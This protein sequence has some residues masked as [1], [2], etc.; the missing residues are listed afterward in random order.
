MKDVKTFPRGGVHLHDYKYLTNK[1][2]IRNAPIPAESVLAIHQHMGSPAECIVQRGDEVREGMLIGKAGGVFS[3]NIHSPVPGIVQEIREI[4]LPN[5]VRS[6]A[7]VIAL[8]GE[9]D[10]SGK[11]HKLLNWRAMSASELLDQIRQKGIVGLGGATFPTPLKYTVR[12]GFRAEYLVING[13]ECEPYLTAD[14][15]LMLE[16]TEEILTG[17]RIVRRILAPENVVLGIEE[18][19]PDAIL[20]MEEA[21]QREK[22][23]FQVVPLKMKY[24]QGDENPPHSS[25]SPWI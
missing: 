9:F 23:D 4:Y 10:Q 8:Q 3:A 24:P 6:K 7:A 17:I 13:V 1:L 2:P 5:G 19:K 12:E 16:K 21:V 22:L 25:I 20:A 18:N 15:R 14:H 11:S